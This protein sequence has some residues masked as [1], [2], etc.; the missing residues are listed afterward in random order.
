[1]IDRVVRRS[2]TLDTSVDEAW[3]LLT[4]A[5][6]LA[7]WLGELDGDRITELDGTVRHVVFDDAV[8]GGRIG[9]TWWQDDGDISEVVF[10]LDENDEGTTVTVEER[11][12]LA[13]GKA[14]QLEDAACSMASWDDR[15]V[16][17]EMTVL[18]R[19]LVSV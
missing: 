17:L 2:V 19:S 15:L 6:E 7:G 1:M 12:V 13:G 16:R 10:T 3:R 4:D 11:A 5:D 18:S 9:F 8:E 14:C